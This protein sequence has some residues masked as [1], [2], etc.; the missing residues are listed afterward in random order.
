M[1]LASDDF[2]Q[3]VVDYW[4]EI[5]SRS[6]EVQ[7]RERSFP[8][9]SQHFCGR[10]PPHFTRH[11]LETIVRWKYTD[12]RRC[13]RALDGLAGVSDDRIREL[14]ALIDQVREADAAR[15]LRGAIPGVGIAGIS[16]LLAAAKPDL[17]PVID[18]FA[19]TAICHYYD[20]PWLK[21]VPRD[22]DGR[23]SADEKS[24]GPYVEFCR[25][26]AADLSTATQSWTPRRVDM[27]LWAIGKALIE[28]GSARA[29]CASKKPSGQ[30][31]A[32]HRVSPA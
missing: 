21:A 10:R 19:L 29:H 13:R 8:E 3:G 26:R 32:T 1:P 20:P 25:D 17:F 9:L 18:V 31:N 15:V 28:S 6:A 7:E 30:D 14:T 22:A 23:F 12:H 4:S 5:E 16:A 27:A 11:E 24:Y 2:E